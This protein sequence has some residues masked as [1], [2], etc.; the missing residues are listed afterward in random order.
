MERTV[1]ESFKGR[2]R[3][4]ERYSINDQGYL[5]PDEKGD[6]VLIGSV[7]SMVN[8]L[9]QPNSTTEAIGS[10]QP[11]I[12]AGTIVSAQPYVMVQPQIGVSYVYYV[13]GI[14]YD[15]E[16]ATITGAYVR[17]M[18][19]GFEHDYSIFQETDGDD[20]PDTIFLESST[21]SL[22]EGVLHFYSVPPATFGFNGSAR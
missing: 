16:L 8:G 13:D 17:A 6:F 21:V 5:F 19:S 10:T 20:G 3:T 12:T 11:D 1:I 18:M 15:T 22:Q 4:L 7:I 14:K 9:V 2:L